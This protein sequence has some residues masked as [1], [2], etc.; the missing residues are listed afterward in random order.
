M[1]ASVPK[2]KRTVVGGVLFLCI[3]H[4][5]D[6][7]FMFPNSVYLPSLPTFASYVFNDRGLYRPKEEVTIKGYARS[8]DRTGAAIIPR[9]WSKRVVWIK[10][11]T[12]ATFLHR[13]NNFLLTDKCR[14][15]LNFF[16]LNS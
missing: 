15:G 10:Y 6:C 1:R 12:H 13:A 4:R 14:S 2:H 9:Y 7:A 16:F 5:N 8:L 11:L 3:N